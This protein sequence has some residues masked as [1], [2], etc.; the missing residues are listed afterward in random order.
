MK[1]KDYLLLLLILKNRADA[2]A[3]Y[4]YK[5]E[6]NFFFNYSVKKKKE[7]RVTDERKLLVKNLK[8]SVVYE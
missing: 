1:L 4:N 5:E 6:S 2:T 8:E 3:F 7:T